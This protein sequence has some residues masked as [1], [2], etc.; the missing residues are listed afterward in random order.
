MLSEWCNKG[1]AEKAENPQGVRTK[2]CPG[3][4]R[5]QS[6]EKWGSKKHIFF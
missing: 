3:M 4:V 1:R 2:M 5:V 6:L